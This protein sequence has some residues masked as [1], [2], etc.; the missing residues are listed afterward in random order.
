MSGIVSN[1]FGWVKPRSAWKEMEYQRARRAEFAK[2][3][4]ANLDA[5][6][7]TMSTAMQNKISGLA[8][9]AGEAALKRVQAAAKAKLDDTTKQIDVAEKLV[10]LSPASSTTSTSGVNTVA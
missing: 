9:L 2:Q 5:M 10:G 8:N 4:Q 1:R 7:N 6:N 3:D